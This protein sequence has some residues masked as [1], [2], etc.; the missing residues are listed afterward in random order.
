M[1]PRP[2]VAS[3]FREPPPGSAGRGWPVG[4]AGTGQALRSG[5]GGQPFS[6]H[7][8]VWPGQ[9][10]GRAKSE[11]IQPFEGLDRDGPNAGNRTRLSVALACLC[12]GG[13]PRRSVTALVDENAL[14][15]VRS[16]N[17]PEMPCLPLKC[18]PSPLPP[19]QWLLVGRGWLRRL[20]PCCNGGWPGFFPWLCHPFLARQE[21]R[22]SAV[23][24]MRFGPSDAA[25]T[26]PCLQPAIEAAVGA[27]STN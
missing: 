9:L 7:G 5:S 16:G 18:D 22:P 12:C 10:L 23:L 13:M 4:W 25:G 6:P 21:T 24:H 20:I 17:P 15:K 14:F 8:C 26:S 3:S 19:R 27:G 1:G 11:D 2:P